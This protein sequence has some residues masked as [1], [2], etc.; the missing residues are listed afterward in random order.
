V[1]NRSIPRQSDHPLLGTLP[2][3]PPWCEPRHCEHERDDAGNITKVHRCSAAALSRPKRPRGGCACTMGMISSTPKTGEGP[4]RST[5]KWCRNPGLPA[6][7]MS[8]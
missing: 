7:G 8:R 5:S 3:C 6:Q 4:R 2:S 1:S